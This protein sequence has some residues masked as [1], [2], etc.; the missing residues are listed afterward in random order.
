MLRPFAS[1]T[2]Q[3]F[4]V[5][6]FQL[7]GEM[8]KAVLVPECNKDIGGIKEEIC[9]SP[10]EKKDGMIGL[11]SRFLRFDS[12]KKSSPESPATNPSTIYYGVYIPCEII[13][14]PDESR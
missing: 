14:G 12:L 4:F 3:K 1:Q 11:F 7:Q 2:K 8:S 13:K 9:I 6:H 10:N 5:Y